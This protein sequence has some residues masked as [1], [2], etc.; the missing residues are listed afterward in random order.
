M[1]EKLS[2]AAA[3]GIA[4]YG[5]AKLIKRHL[6]VVPSRSAEFPSHSTAGTGPD[7]EAANDGSEAG[8]IPY[9]AAMDQASGEV[10][11]D[12][13]AAVSLGLVAEQQDDSARE[14]PCM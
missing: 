7:C 3:C 2:I 10:A 6:V 11:S 8:N 1:I 4:V 14:T 5:L 12:E 9:D 13:A